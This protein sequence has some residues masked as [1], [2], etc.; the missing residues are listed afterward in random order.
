MT[1]M[2]ETQM[3]DALRARYSQQA[4][5]GARYAVAASVRSHAGFDAKRTADFIA[6]DLWPSSGLLLHGHEVKV[7]RSDWLRELKDPS[8]ADE[9]IPY[10]N[11]WWLVVPDAAI[12]RDGELPDGW[13]L[14]AMRG[15]GLKAVRK[16]AWRE[17]LP[18][19]PTRLAALLRAVAADAANHARLAVER[20]QEQA[21]GSS[22]ASL[23]R[24]VE[25]HRDR[26]DSA[27]RR[28]QGAESAAR[29]WQAAYAAAGGLPCAHCGKPVKP[30]KVRTS[31]LYD[32]RHVKAADERECA[33]RRTAAGRWNEVEPA[34]EIEPPGIPSSV[35]AQGAAPE[36]ETG[37]SG[38]TAS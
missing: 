20:E 26:A 13:G 4:G 15:D 27:D 22:V 2:T 16:A 30:A 24:S 5:N 21:D 9:F 3:C 11:H 34:I 32:W 25:Y 7:S 33:D 38:G 28:L 31:F 37:N 1:A 12:V 17:A 6:M 29:A 36:N 19:P 14:L 23:K 10:V 18:L 35:P 8:K